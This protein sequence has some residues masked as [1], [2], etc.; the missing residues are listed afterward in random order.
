[1]YYFTADQH[2]DHINIMKHCNRPFRTVDEM[3][4]TIMN[5]WNLNVKPED[6]VVLAGDISMLPSADLIHRR[7]LSKLVGNKVFLRGNHDHWMKE[8]RYIYNKRIEMQI[9]SVCH[10]PMRTWQNSNH[11]SWQLHGH[12]HGTL[13]PFHNQLDIGVDNAFKLL[14]SYRPFSFNEVKEIMEA[15]N[16][17]AHNVL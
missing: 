15:Q 5:A 16:D 9:V 6:V 4:E 14:G 12:S 1:M 8:K 17:D 13:Q 3:N 10:Y 2:F 11:G 7:F